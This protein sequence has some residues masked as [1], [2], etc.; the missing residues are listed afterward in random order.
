MALE[1]LLAGVVT[2]AVELGYL[3]VRTY[4]VAGRDESWTAC[5]RAP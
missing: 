3:R 1:R 5:G 2:H 4:A